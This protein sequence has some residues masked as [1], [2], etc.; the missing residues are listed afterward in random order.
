MIELPDW[1]DRETW[2]AY[3]EMR[4]KQRR[5]LTDFARKL[6]IKKLLRLYELDPETNHP[7]DVL[8]QSILCGYQGLWP[9]N[10]GRKGQRDA[11]LQ[12]ELRVGKGPRLR[13]Q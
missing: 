3:E 8:E 5:P 10:T 11:E 12:R 7:Q 2:M 4:R 6:A 13:R 9:V 1:I